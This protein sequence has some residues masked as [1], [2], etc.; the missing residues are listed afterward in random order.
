MID[1]EVNMNNIK[2]LIM[3]LCVLTMCFSITVLPA[4][5]M[6]IPTEKTLIFRQFMLL[7][8]TLSCIIKTPIHRYGFPVLLLE[9]VQHHHLQVSSMILELLFWN[10]LV[11]ALVMFLRCHLNAILHQLLQEIWHLVFLQTLMM[12]QRLTWD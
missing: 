6:E 4:M 9:Y 11:E 3:M 2:K 5:A 8:T 1:L 12:W 7:E 10:L